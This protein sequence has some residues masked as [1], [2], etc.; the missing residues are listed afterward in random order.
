MGLEDLMSGTC[1]ESSLG[2]DLRGSEAIYLIH[3][4]VMPCLCFCVPFCQMCGCFA[5][6]KKFAKSLDCQGPE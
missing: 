6:L 2:E 1:A 3:L 4:C 5:H